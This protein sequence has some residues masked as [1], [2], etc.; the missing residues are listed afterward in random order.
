MPQSRPSPL[1]AAPLRLLLLGGS[2][3][4]AVLA[5]R[6]AG[7]PGLASIL[8]LAGATRDPAPQPLLLRVGGWGSAAAQADWMR[9]EAIGAV[10]DATHPFAA[11]I[12]PR[13]AA[14]CAAAGL[15]YLR[16]LRP[17][18]VAG[19]GDRW[20]R[21]PGP[22]AAAEV[23]PETA[24]VLL[25]TGRLSLPGLSGLAGRRLYCRIVDPPTAA[26][27]YPPGAWL[28]GRPPFT[29]AGE[30]R[31]LRDLGIDWIVAKDSGGAG[32]WPKL[33]AARAL[34]LPVALIDRP[35]PPGASVSTVTE[36]LDW[37]ARLRGGAP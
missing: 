29:E 13:T 20:T 25:A 15:P 7:Q 5:K 3:E 11:R 32:G 2:A 33:A 28:Q 31:L 12:G 24:T 10:I 27:P 18:W 37:L 21:I 30:R 35:P 17:G 14:I 19:P 4:A 22:E 36:A 8:S 34:D 6:L 26:F 16:L 23:I 9:R 1:A